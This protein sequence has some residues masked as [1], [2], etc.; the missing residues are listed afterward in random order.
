VEKWFLIMLDGASYNLKMIEQWM[1]DYPQTTFCVDPFHR[2]GR[3]VDAIMKILE[4]SNI[5]D[6]AKSILSLFRFPDNFNI[7]TE[8]NKINNIEITYKFTI[9][10]PTRPLSF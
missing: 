1:N 2:L 3:I 6:L 5:S 8:S 10:C 9:S 7:L 4:F